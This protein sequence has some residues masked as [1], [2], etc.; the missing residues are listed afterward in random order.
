MEANIQFEVISHKEVHYPQTNGISMLKTSI[1]MKRIDPLTVEEQK[2]QE[3]NLTALLHAIK[4]W[5]IFVTYLPYKK[6]KMNWLGWNP[7]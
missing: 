1:K 6:K 7:Q 2:T 3:N 5:I 4:K